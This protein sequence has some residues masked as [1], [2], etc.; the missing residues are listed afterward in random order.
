MDVILS[1]D[2]EK[3][4]LRLPKFQQI[5]VRK[6]LLALKKNPMSGKKLSG[7]LLSYYSLRA[8]PYRIIYQINQI[9]KRIEVSAIIHRQGAYRN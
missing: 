9:E 4:L 7:E 6:K 8:W 3:D 5:K 1:E 2:A